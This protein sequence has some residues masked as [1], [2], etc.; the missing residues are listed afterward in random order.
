M[1][2]GSVYLFLEESMVL[3]VKIFNYIIHKTSL[4]YVIRNSGVVCVDIAEL[5]ESLCG[6]SCRVGFCR[7]GFY[8]GYLGREK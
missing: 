8:G 7:M 4:L 2:D 6:I 1:L 3:V 5:L